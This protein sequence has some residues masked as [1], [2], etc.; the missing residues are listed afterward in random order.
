MLPIPGAG[1]SLRHLGVKKLK[2]GAGRLR[3]ERGS[4]L[5]LVMFI[6]LLLTILG[7]SVLTA[8]VGGAQRTET[9]KNDVQ[10]LHLAEKTLNEAVAYITA[11]LNKA[12]ENGN[13]EWSQEELKSE[14]K[15]FLSELKDGIE[16]EP[17]GDVQKGL[18]A[19][20]EL[21]QAGGEKAV[22]TII[23][24]IFNDNVPDD[25][26]DTDQYVSYTLTL[27]A[28]A[29]VNGVVRKLK[30]NVVIDTYPDFLKYVLGSE[31]NLI[32]NGSPYIEGNIYA[33]N[34]L[35]IS[36]TAHYLYN[37]NHSYVSKPFQLEGEAHVQSL[38]KL[39]YKVGGSDPVTG[40]QVTD[41]KII[42]AS[43][44]KIKNHR[45]FVEVNVESSFVDKVEEATE[46]HNNRQTILDRIHSGALAGYLAGNSNFDHPDVLGEKP[47]PADTSDEGK[48]RQQAYDDTV[49]LLTHPTRSL[50]YK[51]DLVIDGT[52]L[53]GI[54]Y[55]SKVSASGVPYWYVVDG[56]L[57]IDNYG[58][59]TPIDV[60]ANILVT[61]KVEIRGKVQFDS[62][63]YV[64]K[65]AAGGEFNTVVEDATINGLN[66]KELVLISEG[67]ILFNRLAAFDEA[68][69]P[70]NAFFYTDSKADLYGVGSIFS[71]SG[72][73][74]A[75][76]D[77]TINAVRG[78]SARGGSD[79]I[80]AEDESLIRFKAVY[81]NNV[82][83]D[84]QAGLPRVRT[85]NIR[86][87]ELQ[88]E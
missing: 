6:V 20:T 49:A 37:G 25:T 83:G 13:T 84:Q 63:I 3:E 71:L 68:A 78:T 66:N 42:P 38:N 82:F 70:L 17:S 15:K 9:R 1:T 41:M 54:N 29:E 52:E 43:S 51:G 27:T 57:L 14:I 65:A 61:G 24:V 45:S 81:N 12:V 73:F 88:L 22:G 5:V 28:Q 11:S 7:L 18:L 86:V 32:I 46:S 31:H 55:T 53:T 40:T 2:E 58:A 48:E 77:L 80:I 16:D 10:S 34:E 39:S 59:D 30:Q 19:S 69:T 75:K 47:D 72:G 85:V 79:I 62:T 26:E 87:E 56:N 36:D 76:E 44:V 21:S 50:V 4:A 8:A 74:F 67:A 60:R 64:L 33:G 35:K 23:D